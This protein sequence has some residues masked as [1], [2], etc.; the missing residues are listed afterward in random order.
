MGAGDWNAGDAL[1]LPESLSV[2]LS[3]KANSKGLELN[4]GK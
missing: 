1:R 2:C 4:F 3:G